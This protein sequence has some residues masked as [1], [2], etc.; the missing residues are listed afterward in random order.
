MG[1]MSL[2]DM[3][4]EVRFTVGGFGAGADQLTPARVDLWLRWALLHVGRPAVYPHRE[5]MTSGT[6]VLAADVPSYAFSGFGT[7]TDN[8]QAIRRVYNESKGHRLTPMSHR[9]YL[10][11]SRTGGGTIVTGQPQ[12]YAPDGGSLFIYPAPTATFSGN[13]VRVFF[14]R[15]P[16]ALAAAPAI[17]L[18]EDWDEVVVAGAVWRGFRALGVPERAELAKLEFG[19]LINEVYDRLAIEHIED[20]DGRSFEVEILDHQEVTSR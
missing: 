15:K 9:Q 5:L 8:V 14:Y 17:E 18:A 20:H 6:F 2:I 16:I 12:Q 19:Q 3:E 11:A 13:T 7:S 1:A 10:E 4:D